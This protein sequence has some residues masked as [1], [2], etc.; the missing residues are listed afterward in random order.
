MKDTEE[1]TELSATDQAFLEIM[2]QFEDPKCESNHGSEGRGLFSDVGT[3]CTV[4]VVARKSVSCTG[5]SFNICASSLM[6]N[7][8]IIN[9]P[10]A[11]CKCGLPCSVCWSVDIT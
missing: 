9:S 11:M 4:K 8:L 2:D 7:T 5:L 10:K 3:E 6:Y 1:Y